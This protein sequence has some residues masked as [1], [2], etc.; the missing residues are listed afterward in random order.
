MSQRLLESINFKANLIEEI[1]ENLENYCT[2]SRVLDWIEELQ[3]VLNEYKEQ[4]F[5]LIVQGFRE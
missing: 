3:E 4:A 5:E 1:I 2:D